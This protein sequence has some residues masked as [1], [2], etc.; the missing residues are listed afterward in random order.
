A[1]HGRKHERALFRVEL[2]ERVHGSRVARWG[3]PANRS[4]IYMLNNW[5]K[6]LPRMRG[7]DPYSSAPWF[8]DWRDG[9]PRAY[10]PAPVAGSTTWLG[11]AGWRRRGLLSVADEPRSPVER[12][13]D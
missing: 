11:T 1:E 10:G 4:I 2:G 8:G 13:P 12:L 3:R 7:F 5:A 6:H 9:P